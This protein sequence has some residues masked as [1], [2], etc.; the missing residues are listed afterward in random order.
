[1]VT[2]LKKKVTEKKFELKQY[3]DLDCIFNETLRTNMLGSVE[4]QDD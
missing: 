2:V 3:E 1:M 4:E